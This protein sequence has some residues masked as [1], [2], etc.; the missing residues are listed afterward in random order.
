MDLKKEM[1]EKFSHCG[2]VIEALNDHARQKI[3][4]VLIHSGKD[5]LSVKEI[6]HESDL[7]RPA[8]SHHLLILKRAGLVKI[9]KSGT[10]NFYVLD[11]KERLEE[12]KGLIAM[13]D[14]EVKKWNL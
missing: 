5:G 4:T 14:L 2:R 6:T 9:R 3:L 10:K 12:L 8:I 1:D 7:S 11:P 13:L